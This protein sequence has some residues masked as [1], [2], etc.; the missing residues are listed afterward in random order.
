MY[1]RIVVEGAARERG[2]QYGAAAADRVQRSIE[3]YGEVFAHYAGWDWSRVR[4][5]AEAFRA[6]IEAFGATYLE[7]ICGIAEGAGVDDVDVLAI[8]VR[9]EVMFAATARDAD[10][11]KRL[12]PECSAFAVTPRR[13]GGRLVAGQNWDWLVH[14]FDTCVVLESHQE[15]GPSFVTVVEAGLLAKAGMNSSGVAL[16]TNALVSD[17]DHG[18]PGV[19]YHVLLRA[20]LDAETISD[21][22]AA[23][24]RSERS[25]SANYLL[26]QDGVAIDV[27]AAPGDYSRLFV[28][29]PSDGVL[30]HTNHFD[31][32]R[33]DGRDVSTWAMPD[34]PFRMAR[35][36]DRV[37]EHDGPLDAAFWRELLADHATYPLGVC[38]HPDDRLPGP[39]RSATIAALIMDPDERRMWAAAG[40]PCQHPWEELDVTAL[41]GRPSPIRR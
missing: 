22:L 33:F 18:R 27:E 3:A 6:P 26:A 28:T 34:S 2:R 10:R 32:P 14:A 35:L 13:A 20:I 24:Q 21:G 9:T 19:P 40:N 25:S 16:C 1:P 37:A 31:N 36:R 41:T 17:A 15:D 29:Y 30:L 4:E 7:E 12:P 23:L 5:E 11:T 8:N 39:E 38:C